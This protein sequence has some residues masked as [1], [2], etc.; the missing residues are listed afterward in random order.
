MRKMLFC[1]ALALCVT[2]ASVLACVPE[3]EMAA[4]AEARAPYPVLSMSDGYNMAV[5]GAQI[6]RVSHAGCDIAFRP[7]CAIEYFVENCGISSRLMRVSPD[8]PTQLFTGRRRE[9]SGPAFVGKYASKL[10]PLL[11]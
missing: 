6:S 4:V 7:A 8:I 11:A 5:N 10:L 9:A 3:P 2:L 1:V